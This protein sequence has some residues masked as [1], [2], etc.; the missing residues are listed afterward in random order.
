MVTLILTPHILPWG[1]IETF[2]TSWCGWRQHQ[3]HGHKEGERE[4]ENEQVLIIT[5]REGRK[6]LRDNSWEGCIH[7]TRKKKEGERESSI[8]TLTSIGRRQANGR[9]G[10]R[11][12]LTRRGKSWNGMKK[13]QRNCEL[14]KHTKSER[15]EEEREWAMDKCKHWKKRKSES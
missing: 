5:Q 7:S 10:T 15:G 1:E 3:T 6:G 9:E 8:F 12:R 4:S 14:N 11:G 13:C 2:E